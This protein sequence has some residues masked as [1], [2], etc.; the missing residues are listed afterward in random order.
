MRA[1]SNNPTRGKLDVKLC[2]S[3]PKLCEESY[4]CWE[5]AIEHSIHQSSNTKP[6]C[7]NRCITEPFPSPAGSAKLSCCHVALMFSSYQI[8]N[9]HYSAAPILVR[10]RVPAIICDV[11]CR[12]RVEQVLPPCIYLA[13]KFRKF[14]RQNRLVIRLAKMKHITVVTS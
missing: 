9:L 13:N 10:V 8:Y 3:V 4:G 6:L 12:E 2:S 14:R 1:P 7:K 5:W 11:L